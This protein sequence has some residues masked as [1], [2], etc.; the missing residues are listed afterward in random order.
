MSIGYANVELDDFDAMFVNVTIKCQ[1]WPGEPATYS[2]PGSSA[3]AEILEIKIEE[4]YDADGNT[5][6]ID[7]AL[8]VAV[9]DYLYDN[10]DL[11]YEQALESAAESYYDRYDY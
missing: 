8:E 6:D 5:V 4:V 11:W 3:E 9:E 7:E 2:Y 10:P 1:V